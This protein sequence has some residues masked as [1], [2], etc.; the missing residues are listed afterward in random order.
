[1]R[2]FFTSTCGVLTV[3]RHRSHFFPRKHRDLVSRVIFDLKHWR[4][5]IL[6]VPCAK[7][8]DV[9]GRLPE[10]R[11]VLFSDASTSFGMAG[12]ILF[13]IKNIHRRGHSGL[14]WQMGWDDWN[15]VASIA[16]LHPR[17]IKIN[18]AEFVAALITCET[19]SQF[20]VGRITVFHFDNVTAEAWLDSSRCPRARF[21]RC[22][23]GTHLYM[24]KMTM[25]IRT[26]WVPSREN[27]HADICSGK[28]F[29]GRSSG[30]IIAGVKLL[31]V[32]PKWQ[33]VIKFL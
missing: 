26:R 29:S 7:F 27:V 12:V 25:K 1:M 11:N 6:K 33:N 15:R 31:R 19:F 5:Y 16:A 2:Q 18:V 4:R 13:Q 23:Q 24:I 22:A 30:H 20:C 10:N 8:V 9:L 32:R 21:D 3:A 28:R 14:F 17:H